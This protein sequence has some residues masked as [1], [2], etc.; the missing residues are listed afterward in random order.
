MKFNTKLN[1][2]KAENLL[3]VAFDVS[4]D[5]LNCYSQWGDKTIHFFNDEFE[6]RIPT[7]GKKL[8]D[9]FSYA[10][11]QGF[12]GLHI[13]CEPTGGYENKLIDCALK[14]GCRISYVSGESVNKFQAVENNESDKSDE[15]DPRVIFK[16]FLNGK[17]IKYRK[18]P[19][20]YQKLR[21]LS[22]FYEQD[23]QTITDIKNKIH[24]TLKNLFPDFSFKN[25]FL[26]ETS[27]IA[28][29]T[30]FNGNP[31][32][33]V[34]TGKTRFV[35]RMK[36]LSPRARK[37]TLERLFNDAISSVKTDMDEPIIELYQNRIKTLWADYNFHKNSLLKTRQAM[38]DIYDQLLEKREQVPSVIKGLF[39]KI[40]LARIISQTG[41]L[42]DFN[43]ARQIKRFGGLHLRVRQSGKY[44]GKVKLSKK[45]RIDLRHVMAQ[46]IFHLIK[47]DRLL[48]QF[49][50]RKKDQGMPG[51]KA[52][53]VVMRKAID[54]I[55]ALSK[56]D[57]VFDE[58]RLFACESQFAKAA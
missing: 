52:M 2:I 48:G 22:R 3:A 26:F 49:Y 4:M 33:I 56:P 40:N 54:I 16:L 5:K 6:N 7:I 1:P 46:S 20:L 47:K 30:L 38:E 39:S 10:Q 23:S 45:G 19:L 14:K 11:S 24:D 37:T 28:F 17:L 27:G 35:K 43:S 21:T 31:Y 12:A 9:F 18:L 44:M 41:P 36:K 58:Q 55:F 8:N 32:A 42:S 57:A 53:T 29:M 15:K 34:K 25:A 13:V 50:H 51:T